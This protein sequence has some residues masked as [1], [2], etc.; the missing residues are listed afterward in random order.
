VCKFDSLGFEFWLFNLNLNL[1]L[2]I[3]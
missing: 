2:N 1:N 3:L